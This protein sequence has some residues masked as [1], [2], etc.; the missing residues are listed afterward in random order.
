MDLSQETTWGSREVC[1]YSEWSDKTLC[2]KEH[3]FQMA[4]R[5]LFQLTDEKSTPDGSKRG[6]CW[7]FYRGK[8]KVEQQGNA[9]APIRFLSLFYGTHFVRCSIRKYSV[10]KYI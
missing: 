3:L 2:D 8:K 7:F 9:Y 10:V 5:E 6:T 4:A 1:A